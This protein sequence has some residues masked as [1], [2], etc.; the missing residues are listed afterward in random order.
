VPP[1]TR[2]SWWR[3]DASEPVKR[4]LGLVGVLVAILA[5]GALTRSDLFLDLDWL[6]RN[7]LLI[8]TQAS[9]I[10]VITVGMTFVMIGGGIDLSVG[11][12]VALTSVWC[13][14]V[15]TQEFGSAGM[16]FAALAVGVVA[17]SINGLLI[18]Y[19]RL[20]P[21]IAT[22]AMLVAARG[23][24]QMISGKL[25]QRVDVSN[26]FISQLSFDKVLG[27]PALVLIMLAVGVLGWI[28]LNRT[29]FGRTDVRHRR[30]RRG[31]PGW[32]ASTSGV[33]RCCCT[34]CPACAVAS[35]PS[36]WSRS[37]ARGGRPRRPVRARRDRRPAIIG[38]TALTGGRGTIV[39]ALLGVVI[40]KGITNL[41]IV[42]NLEQEYQLIVKGAII[43]APFW[44]NSSASRHCEDAGVPRPPS[45][46]RY[47]PMGCP[48]EW[49]DTG[50]TLPS[51]R[52]GGLH[53]RVPVPPAPARCRVRGRR[54]RAAH[55]VHR[56]RQ[57][58]R[59]QQPDRQ[60]N[61]GDNTAPGK[62]I[63]IGFLGAGGDHGW[64]AAITANAE[65]QAKK[66]SEVTF[67][68][69][70]AGKDV[71]EQRPASSR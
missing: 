43:V 18:A 56:Q 34:R 39:G 8:L 20:V 71:T 25:T 13:T 7:E 69:V 66:Y 12:L 58:R 47:V 65:A 63:K 51:Y 62:A 30:Q 16:I 36:S 4:N 21:F 27:I 59:Q 54:R 37:P 42:N 2:T 24:A 11:A 3:G 32:P 31:R 22:L 41:F 49:T 61:S 50:I 46:P 1:S 23:L 17:G 48:S 14:T 10:G 57:D 40:F 45:G 67:V 70:A 6:W 64:I 60:H 5:V 33:T 68:P 9:A 55:R 52:P 29:T 44:F 28:L 53:D 15:A 26:R 38:G 19:G 35:A